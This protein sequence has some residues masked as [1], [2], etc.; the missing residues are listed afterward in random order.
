M[1]KRKFMNDL[2]EWKN[3]Q[4]TSK[5]KQCLLV[6]GARQ[7]G[8]STLIEEFGRTY[9]DNFI[10]VDFRK[11]KELRTIFDDSFDINS[12]IGKFSLLRPGIQFIPGKTLLLLDEIQDCPN[13]R[14]SLK[15]WAL[16]ARFDVIASGSL[17]GVSLVAASVP[18]G[19][20]KVKTLHAMD[21]EEFL[22]ALGIDSNA[23]NTLKPYFT[24]GL[25]IPDAINNKMFEYLRTYMITGGMP[26]VINKY[27][28]THD[29]FS[30]DQEQNIIIDGYRDDIA[31]YTETDKRIKARSCYDSISRQLLKDNHKFQYKEVKQGKTSS[32]FMSSIDWIENAGMATRCYNLYEP[33]FPIKG[34]IDEDKFRLYM[35]DI[36]LL[37]A[38]YGYQTKSSVFN[39]QLYGN[40]K[41][42]LYESLIADFL[43][44]K[45]YPLV[46]Y[47][48]QKGTVELEFFIEK[49]SSI[50]PIEVKANNSRTAS[51]NNILKDEHIPYGYKFITGNSGIDKKK[52]TLPLYMAMFL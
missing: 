7:V 42:A 50:I 12:L 48:N 5:T 8:K 19:Y 51:L 2:L 33:A 11:E 30:V 27:L 20:E 28:T 4:S 10:S 17:L 9:Y 16:D 14:S 13:A 46:Y 49:D 23:I 44:K 25:H 37:T 31:C 18:V 34:Y 36:G 41:G 29:F 15:Y 1:L 52:I 6:K 45:N 43:I 26:N 32:Y 35:N 24:N 22:W 21:F 40:L 39:N 38:S 47:K 3:T